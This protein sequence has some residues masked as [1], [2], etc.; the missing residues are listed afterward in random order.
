MKRITVRL[1]EATWDNLQS[2]AAEQFPGTPMAIVVRMILRRVL[3]SGHDGEVPFRHETDMR[4]DSTGT[5]AAHPP[6]APTVTGAATDSAQDDTPLVLDG[7]SDMDWLLNAVD[8]VS[9]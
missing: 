1:D 2:Y 9:A 5:E 4:G 7:S 8:S 6:T 3:T